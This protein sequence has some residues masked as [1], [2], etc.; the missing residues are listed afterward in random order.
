MSLDCLQSRR[1]GKAVCTSQPDPAH[2]SWQESP[3]S[4]RH[5]P[6]WTTT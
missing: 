4:G 5:G 3:S 6:R 2:S 1:N